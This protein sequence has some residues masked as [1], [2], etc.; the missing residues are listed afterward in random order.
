[1]GVESQ[2]PSLAAL[3][4][5]SGPGFL[6]LKS[7]SVYDVSTGKLSSGAEV[8]SDAAQTLTAGMKCGLPWILC[9][10]HQTDEF[11]TANV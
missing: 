4:S 2:I 1:M 11:S 6:D 3:F 8:F 10:L 9:L 5:L 7:S